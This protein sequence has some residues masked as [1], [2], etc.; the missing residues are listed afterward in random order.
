MLKLLNAPPVPLS[1]ATAVSQKLL[2]ILPEAD[3]PLP[4]PHMN[5][6]VIELP[7]VTRVR[8]CCCRCWKA[9]TMHSR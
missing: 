3:I 2:D 1:E 7:E 6:Q 4:D 5:P 9:T 8:I